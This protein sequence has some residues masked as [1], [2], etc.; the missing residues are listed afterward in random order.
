MS[1]STNMMPFYDDADQQH[2][3]D[4]PDQAEVEMEQKQC[5]ESAPA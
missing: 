3:A 2:Q 5:R 4:R 1:K